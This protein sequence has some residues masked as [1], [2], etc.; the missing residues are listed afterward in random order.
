MTNPIVS[1]PDI[2]SKIAIDQNGEMIVNPEYERFFNDIE[3][4]LNEAGVVDSINFPQ[5]RAGL[6]PPPVEN[7][8]GMAFG[9]APGSEFLTPVFVSTPFSTT[10]FRINEVE[11]AAGIAQFNFTLGPATQLAIGEEVIISGYEDP[12]RQIYNGTKQVTSSASNF[13]KIASIP[14]AGSELQK[15][16]MVGS[17][18]RKI[19][20]NVIVS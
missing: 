5:Y 16:F 10:T 3:E 2:G 11:D 17:S 13:F 18:W 15:D 9:E 20:D 6:L 1:K 7:I 8:G 12:S 14:F 4:A 19:I